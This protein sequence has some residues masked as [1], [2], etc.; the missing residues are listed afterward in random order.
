MYFIITPFVH[1]E[2][3][4]EA[5]RIILMHTKLYSSIYKIEPAM[6][7]PTG[8]GNIILLYFN[9]FYSSPPGRG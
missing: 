3:I 2:L 8:E 6:T 4:F 5:E 1:I 7:P 9:Q